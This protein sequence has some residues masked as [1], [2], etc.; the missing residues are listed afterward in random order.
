MIQILIKRVELSTFCILRVKQEAKIIGPH[1]VFLITVG[2]RPRELHTN[3]IRIPFVQCR[4]TLHKERIQF[5]QRRIGVCLQVVAF[6]LTGNYFIEHLWQNKKS[7]GDV[8]A[9]TEV[10][11]QIV[12]RIKS[13][14]QNK[15]R[16]CATCKG[17]DY[18]DT[19]RLVGFVFL[20]LVKALNRLVQG[21]HLS[22]A[23]HR[24]QRKTRNGTH[25]TSTLGQRLAV[26][27]CIYRKPGIPCM[28]ILVQILAHSLFCRR[29]NGFDEGVA[30]LNAAQVID[31]RIKNS[32]SNIV[33]LLACNHF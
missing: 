18:Y 4:I 2:S 17:T 26:Q 22:S 29:L 3:R 8:C 16:A 10:C 31:I 33:A 21:L 19:Q 24:F 32:K 30:F 20:D 23:D 12:S 9:L 11:L 14:R 5:S 28:R 27:N 7:S 15:A 6:R 1:I 13:N 25:L